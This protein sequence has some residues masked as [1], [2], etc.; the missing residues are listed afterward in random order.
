MQFLKYLAEAVEAERRFGLWILRLRPQTFV[1]ISE[2]L[3]ANLKKVRQTSV[4]Q[5]VSFFIVP[6]RLT[7]VSNAKRKISKS[8]KSELWNHLSYRGLSYFFEVGSQT[9]RAFAKKTKCLQ[10]WRV[11]CFEGLL[12]MYV[13]MEISNSSHSNKL[14]RTKWIDIFCL[15]NIAKTEK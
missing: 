9:F 14:A 6:Q 3:A 4:W 7:L 11:S 2:S 8:N 13:F 10:Q 1:I 12:G 5:T 15:K